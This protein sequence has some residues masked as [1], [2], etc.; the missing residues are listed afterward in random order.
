MPVKP[1]VAPPVLLDELSTTYAKP[2][3]EEFAV[4]CACTGPVGT[5]LGAVYVACG[6]QNV[7]GKNVDWQ[8]TT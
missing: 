4:I 3:R 8:E 7:A 6:G 2:A 1:H 5:G